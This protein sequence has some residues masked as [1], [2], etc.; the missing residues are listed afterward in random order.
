MTT[1]RSTPSPST[2]MI[3][4]EARQALL[5]EQVLE[6][7]VEPARAG[8]STPSSRAITDADR[9]R[10]ALRGRHALH[11]LPRH[12]PH[13]PAA[14]VDHREPG[15]PVAQEELLL[16]IRER[17]V[18]RDRHRLRIHHVGHA[19]VLDP[20]GEVR[21]RLRRAGGAGEEPADEGEPDA[22]DG[23]TAT[24]TAPR[25]RPPSAT[26]RPARAGPRSAW[27]GCGRR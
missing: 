25:R 22:A 20:P 21:L 9:A 14:R 5:A 16:G 3:A 26:R 10:G 1:P 2:A 15:P 11:R 13:E 17:R 6:R 18:L 12:D 4:P 7:L 24:G 19:D 8:R 23:V 27:P